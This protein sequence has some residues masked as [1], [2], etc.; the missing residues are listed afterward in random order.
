LAGVYLHSRFLSQLSITIDELTLLVQHWEWKFVFLSVHTKSLGN[1]L[2]MVL[3]PPINFL[4]FEGKLSS[5]EK[6]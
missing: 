5:D 2:Q 6:G 4:V 1:Y 3:F